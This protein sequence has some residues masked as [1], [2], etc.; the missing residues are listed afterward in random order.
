MRVIDGARGQRCLQL[1]EQSVVF[2]APD[3]DVDV[4]I[5][6]VRA[7]DAGS[8]RSKSAPSAAKTIPGFSEVQ[9]ARSVVNSRASSEYDG[10]T[11]A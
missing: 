1:T 5:R 3:V 11:G 10:A 7:G 6:V 8:A 9:I 2:N 4:T